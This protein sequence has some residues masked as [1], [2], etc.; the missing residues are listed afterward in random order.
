MNHGFWGRHQNV[1]HYIKDFIQRF[2]IGRKVT[3]A[4]IISGGVAGAATYYAFSQ[5]GFGAHQSNYLIFL[6]N[7]DL[8]ILLLLAL[9]IAK[10]LAALWIARRTGQAAAKLH[11]RFVVLFSLLAMT[12]AVVMMI[13]SAFMF[14]MGIQKWF[15]DRVRTALS[16]STNVAQAYLEE[17]KKVIGASVY[18][19]ARDLAQEYG[20]LE[21]N[22]ELFSQF[23]D[24]S[25]KTRNLDEALVFRAVTGSSTPEVE[26][27]ARSRLSLGLE[28]ESVSLSE[29]E[30]AETDVVIKTKDQGDR[31]RALKRIAPD[32]DAYLLVGRIVD[33]VVTKRIAEVQDA[34]SNY[35]Q[36]EGDQHKLQLNFMLMFIAI[37]LLLLLT[38]V[39]VALTFAGR[40]ARPIGALISASE[41]VRQG[42]LSVRVV[43]SP[44]KDE[45]SS[46]M[47][48]FNRMIERRQEDQQELVQANQLSDSR[49]RFI[50]DVLAG[51]TSG[52]LSI[53]KAGIIQVMNISAAELLDAKLPEAIDQNIDTIFP[54]VLDLLKTSETSEE[55]VMGQIKV[56]RKGGIL[57]LFVRI[58]EEKEED[59]YII[60]FSD[61]TE[62][63]SA[64]RKAAWADI[65]QRIAHEIRNPLTPIQLSAERLNRKY[66]KQ[67]KDDP[68]NFESCVET[69]IRQVSN[70]GDMVK[71]FSNFARLPEPKIQT[72]DLLKLV[73][74]N[75]DQ[76]R[77]SHP[78]VSF[79]LKIPK[80]YKDLMF[81]CD[82][83]QITQVLT[84]LIQN[85]IDSISTRTKVKEMGKIVIT[86]DPF[87]TGF[88][89]VLQDN[90]AGFPVENR[91]QL[92]DPYITHKER[93]TG[94][95]LAIVKKIIED[96][97][98][99][100]FLEDAPG[101]GA[102]VRMRFVG[103]IK[104]K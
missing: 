46:L 88:N 54:E 55:H 2:R 52:I 18:S 6:L 89:L 9:I 64:Q 14:N 68:E 5:S 97:G 49:R 48:S 92:T 21:Q 43:P 23:L 7:V 50:E 53:S 47:D 38:A 11:T 45:I 3:I 98:G 62:L 44:D 96:H 15:S 81:Q 85:S 99:T 22:P 37:A 93:G 56:P 63:L 86:L 27:V 100:L 65:A 13:F 29:L 71:E 20:M 12:P 51:V 4:L 33:P 39:W 103:K 58:V 90:G 83:A 73:Q 60:T 104:G 17:H 36:L 82:A 31:V 41:S 8:I 30:K 95:G 91:E 94:L 34:V 59:G 19:F 75:I 67:I 1:L 101:G 25:A 76:Y 102:Q 57:T 87:D 10:R 26:V 74:Q 24:S 42:D 35:N 78:E 80:G 28:F 84:N 16:E 61:I 69:I 72:E 77:H 70:L 40:I 79:E 66:L 32:I